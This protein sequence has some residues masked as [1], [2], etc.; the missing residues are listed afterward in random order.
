MRQEIGDSA[1]GFEMSEDCKALEEGKKVYLTIGACMSG[2]GGSGDVAWEGKR[3]SLE[4]SMRAQLRRWMP[5]VLTLTFDAIDMS[6]ECTNNN[7]K[8]HW[9]LIGNG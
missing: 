4:G 2:G 3:R 8:K 1:E 6:D 7:G 5:S 9:K